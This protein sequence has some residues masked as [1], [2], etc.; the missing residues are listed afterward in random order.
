MITTNITVYR[1]KGTLYGSY[2]QGTY[3]GSGY[4]EDHFD[5]QYLVKE[6]RLFGFRIFKWTLDTEDVPVYASAQ[7]ACLGYTDWRSEFAEYIT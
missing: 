6:W 5:R 4:C 1:R 7:K 3:K 2:A